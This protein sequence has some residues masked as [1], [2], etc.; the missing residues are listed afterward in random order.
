VEVRGSCVNNSREEDPP[1]MYCSTDGE[2]LVPIGKCLCNIGYEERGVTCQGR[3]FLS[4]AHFSLF[5][6][7]AHFL[8]FISVM[9]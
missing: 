2:W 3:V 5:H 1:K 6:F 8:P 9:Y 4:H 7:T